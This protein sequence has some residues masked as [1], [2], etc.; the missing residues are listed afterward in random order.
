MTSV[1]M[2]LICKPWLKREGRPIKIDNNT[3][4]ELS[5]C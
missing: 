2:V 5:L 3:I 4:V 1:L